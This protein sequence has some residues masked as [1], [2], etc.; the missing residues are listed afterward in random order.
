MD[1]MALTYTGR[2]A[3]SGTPVEYF[4]GLHDEAEFGSERRG[5]V[6]EGMRTE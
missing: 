1:L 2:S 6:G 3:C 5:S 4:R